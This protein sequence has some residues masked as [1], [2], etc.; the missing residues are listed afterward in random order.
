MKKARFFIIPCNISEEVLDV[1]PRH[2]IDKIHNIKH[3][4]V[5]RARTA[6]RFIKQTQ[7]P[8]A[9]D[10]IQIIEL[11]TKDRSI[12][13]LNEILTWL[14]NGHDVG[15]LSEAG[16]PGIA[17]PGSELIDRLQ[18]KKIS[19][20]PLIGPSS[21][22]LALMASG[23]NGQEFHFHGYLPIKENELIN[24]IKQLEKSAIGQSSTQIF[25]ETPY[26]NDRMLKILC[27]Q[28]PKKMKLCLASDI[29]GPAEN[30]R[31][32]SIEQWKKQM[33]KIGK[34]PTVFLI[35]K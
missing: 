31:T 11:E 28:L 2:T 13:D 33:P 15:L 1:L 17:D 27:A 4:V 12:Y 6:R 3:Y 5:E 26:R 21:I 32:Q 24:K 22:L 9:I 19:I 34:L 30:I 10:E 16:C 20:V 23:M 18:E 29:T 25:I 7:P 14:K 8:Y 35:C